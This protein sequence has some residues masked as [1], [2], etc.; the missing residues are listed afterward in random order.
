MIEVKKIEGKTEEELLSQFN[1]DDIHYKLTEIPGKL[2]KGK[3]YEIEVINKEDVKSFIKNFINNLAITMDVKINVEIRYKDD[4]Y[5]V[6]LI[7][8]SNPILIG[9]DG[10]TLNSIQ[11]LLHQALSIAT[12]FNIRINVDAA[13]YKINK[14]KRLEQEIKKIS[15]EVVAS[16]IEVK[17]DPMNSYDRRIVHNI[18][19]EFKELKSES[20]G[21]DPLR[22]VVISY[23]ED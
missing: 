14:E 3:K 9:K 8:D 12:G 21:E 11:L 6:M 1:L 18:V 22:Y 15:K 2:F 5:Y 16:K 10:R 19:G 17:L 13:G 4:C 20:F 23:K 7:S